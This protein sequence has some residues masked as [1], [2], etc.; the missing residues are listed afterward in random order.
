MHMFVQEENTYKECS[1]GMNMEWY[2]LKQ[3][4]SR[5]TKQSNKQTTQ[6]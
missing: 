3:R 6:K 5:K 1:F 2:H 4:I